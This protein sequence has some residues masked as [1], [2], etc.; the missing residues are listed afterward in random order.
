[1]VDGRLREDLPAALSYLHRCGC[2]SLPIVFRPASCSRLGLAGTGG[3]VWDEIRD[4]NYLPDELPPRCCG[5]GY[6]FSFC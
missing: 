5:S 1:M 3:L 4:A 6:A 2:H